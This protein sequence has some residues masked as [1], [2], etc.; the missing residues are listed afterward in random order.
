MRLRRVTTVTIASLLPALLWSG[1]PAGAAQAAT[2][3]QVGCGQTITTSTTLTADVG[4]CPDNGIIVGANDITLNL[5][6]HHV[7]GTPKPGDGAGVL[8]IDRQGVTVENGTVSAFD[9]GVV[10]T[11]GGDNVVSRI[12]AEDNIGSSGNPNVPDTELGD[13]ILLEGTSGNKVTDNVARDNGPFS[14]IGLISQSDSDHTF[15]SAPTADNEV[16]HNVVTD[17]VACRFG[18]FCDNDGIR[19]EPGVG[20]NNAVLSNLV[21][22]N[23][24][25][26]I[27]LFAD[28]DH[29]TVQADTVAA[30]GFHGAVPGDG[31]RVFSSY[32]LISGNVV[33]GN[34]AGGVS[35][36]RRPISPPGSLPPNSVT[37]NPRGMNNRLVRNVASGNRI[38]DLYD[39]NPGCDNNIWRGNVGPVATP[40]CTLL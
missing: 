26:G 39:S 9:A 24:L 14:G 30:N 22:R 13:G 7:F 38:V 8:L 1:V 6:G 36:G 15:S 32:D 33:G 3:T 16:A 17:N 18:P 10:I 28:A 31:I 19:L 21:E 5:A 20:P 23:G 27:S 34:A 25:D 35:V 2:T 12:T 40:P 29:N 4:P 37:G 11:N